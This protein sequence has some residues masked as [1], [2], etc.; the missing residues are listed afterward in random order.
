ML[1]CDQCKKE[2]KNWED[3]NIVE[4]KN[5]NG[6]GGLGL[7]HQ[8]CTP[9][10]ILFCTSHPIDYRNLNF[11]K[12]LFFRIILIILF[13]LSITM[14]IF[15]GIFSTEAFEIYSESP[16]V[17]YLM[18]GVLA[19]LFF[20]V[21]LMPYRDIIKLLKLRKFKKQTSPHSYC[22]ENGKTYE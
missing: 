8:R 1:K 13:L 2:I 22:G 7:Y 11:R 9:K 15:Y 14:I 18:C 17:F 6:Y 10:R 3:L 19:F 5:K 4:W 21:Y 12:E 20:V 16:D